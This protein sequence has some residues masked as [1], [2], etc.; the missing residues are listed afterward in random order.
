M[1]NSYIDIPL[2]CVITNKRIGPQGFY[3]SQ[4]IRSLTENR[5]GREP[6]TL[7]EIIIPYVKKRT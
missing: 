7:P 5:G 1:I 4:H 3:T 2:Q 6:Y